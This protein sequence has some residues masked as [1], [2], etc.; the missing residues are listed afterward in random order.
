MTDVQC[1]GC[2]KRY[3]FRGDPRGCPPCPRCGRYPDPAA[4]DHDA[5]ALEEFKGFL[6]QRKSDRTRAAGDADAG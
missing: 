2:G 1:G 4:L 3:G 6:R 5:R